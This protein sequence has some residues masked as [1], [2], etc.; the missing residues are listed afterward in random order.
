MAYSSS[1]LTEFPGVTAISDRPFHPY[2]YE[3]NHFPRADAIVQGRRTA[4]L[5]TA[6]NLVTAGVAGTVLATLP[7]FIED[8][9]ELQQVFVR[10]AADMPASPTTLGA[11]NVKVL[12]AGSA[13][14]ARTLDE[15]YQSINGLSSTPTIWNPFGG[16]EA[17]LTL[18]A[19]SLSR[20]VQM[21][22][23]GAYN[24]KNIAGIPASAKSFREGSR[25]YPWVR[26]GEALQFVVAVQGVTAT[27]TVEIG[28]RY[29]E[30]LPQK[31]AAPT[32][33]PGTIAFS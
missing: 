5:T 1:I 33:A 8:M 19:S 24:D 11:F 3:E 14:V 26:Q 2:K 18:V 16:G 4:V 10:Y 29:V 13:A 7:A 9:V 6:V 20:S 30:V 12:P 31:V 17:R 22:S 28:V 32:F 25:I 21:C 23:L 27:Q 15:Q